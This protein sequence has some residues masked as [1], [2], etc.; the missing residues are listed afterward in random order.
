MSFSPERHTPRIGVVMPYFQRESRLLHRAL[1]S[2]AAQEYSPAQVVVVDDGSPRPAVDEITPELRAAL[3]GLTV[4]RQSNQGVAAARNAGLKALSDDVSDVA[5]LDSDD[6]WESS[7]LRNAAAALAA[8][9]D[10]FFANARNEGDATDW[11]CGHPLRDQ[12]R[13]STAVPGAPGVVRWCGGVPALFVDGCVFATPATVFRRAIMPEL[14]FPMSFRRAGEDQVAFWNLLIRSAVIMYCAEPTVV[15]GNRGLGTFRNSM[16]G[17]AAHL[18]RLGDEIRWRRYMMRYDPLDNPLTTADR[19]R[20]Q[21]AITARRIAALH[22]AL[23]LLRRG[24]NVFNEIVY[25]FRSD[26]LCAA[27]WCAELPRLLYRKIAGSRD[28]RDARS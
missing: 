11:L 9:A 6:C 13:N 15:I 14:R 1:S 19:R 17:S 28:R 7:H 5:L 26:P 12:L 24:R 8:G 20:V 10:F 22:S 21:C 3:C 16:Y 4:I 18:V 23:H 27:S 2:V 25:L